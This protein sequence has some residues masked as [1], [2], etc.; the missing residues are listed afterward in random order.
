[1]LFIQIQWSA[2]RMIVVLV[3]TVEGV[4]S[5]HKSQLLP[6]ALQQLQFAALRNITP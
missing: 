6:P 2:K 4:E 1:M 3:A 5:H